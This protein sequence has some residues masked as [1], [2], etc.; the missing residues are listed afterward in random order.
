MKILL[1]MVSRKIIIIDW[2]KVATANKT[3][4]VISPSNK[5]SQYEVYYSSNSATMHIVSINSF[6]WT[7]NKCD[8]CYQHSSTDHETHT[9]KHESHTHHNDCMYDSDEKDKLCMSFLFLK[10]QELFWIE[11]FL[12]FPS[13]PFR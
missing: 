11:W 7:P 2:M 10:K 13:T 3:F 6:K 12:F 8:W 9:I 4:D 5:I 1:N